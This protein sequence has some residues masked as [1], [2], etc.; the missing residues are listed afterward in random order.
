MVKKTRSLGV[1][2]PEKRGGRVR[3]DQDQQLADEVRKHIN[4][5]PKMESHF[6]RANTG[7]QYLSPDLNI[8]KMYLLYLEEHNK[9]ERKA[10]LS[11]YSKA[12]ENMKL[13]FHSPKKDLCGLCDAYRKGN[14][15]EQALICIDYEK[16]I[17]EKC[18]ARELKE[19]MKEKAKFNPETFV[20]SVFDLQQVLYLPKSNRGELFYKR[21]LSCYNFTVYELASKTGYCYLH[22]EGLAKRGSNEIASNLYSYLTVVDGEKKKEVALFCDGCRGQNKNSILP[23][24]LMRFVK[25]AKSITSVTV[26]Y[27]ATNHGQSEG[28]AMHS[29]IERAMKNFGDIFLPAQLAALIKLSRRNPSQ[30][31]VHENQTADIYDWKQLSRDVHI[32]KVRKTVEGKPV[33]WTKVMALKVEKNDP[34]KILVTFSHTDM[35]FSTIAIDEGQRKVGHQLEISPKKYQNPESLSHHQVAKQ[36][37][38]E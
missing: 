29:T 28:D 18:K 1:M 26:S 8:N 17:Q 38:F 23:A 2:E 10:S 20:T 5:F 14:E 13:K 21:R 11:F 24:M 30:Y 35:N 7:Y 27:F 36:L 25:H 9:N 6:C 3:K 33:D 19:E 12:V 4:R 37:M 32:L 22:H 31:I 15:G 34:S 16:H